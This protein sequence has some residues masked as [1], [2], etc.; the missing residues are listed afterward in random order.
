MTCSVSRQSNKKFTLLPKGEQGRGYLG[1]SSKS[2]LIW[3]LN[4]PAGADFKF[5][6]SKTVIYAPG[7]RKK[8]PLRTLPNSFFICK[9]AFSATTSRI[10]RA[11]GLPCSFP[12]E[13]PKFGVSNPFTLLF[14]N[15][16]PVPK[17]T[18]PKSACGPSGPLSKTRLLL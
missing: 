17:S 13:A 5:N 10:Y 12:P 15:T 3:S 9:R 16:L 1:G 4:F 6:G 18:T 8:K 2:T 7:K 11:P 14:V